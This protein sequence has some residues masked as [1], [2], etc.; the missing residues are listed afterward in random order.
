[1]TK[2]KAHHHKSGENRAKVNKEAHPKLDEREFPRLNQFLQTIIDNANVWL[3]VL[4]EK[5]NVVIWNNAA[6][7]ISGYSREEVVG[8]R[9]IWDWLYPDEEYRKWIM[10]SVADVLQRGRVDEDVETRIRRKDG[11]IRIISWNERNLVDE[12]GK[13]IGS[14]AIG[15]DVTERKRMQE[16]LEHYSKHLEQLVAERTGK[17]AE[18][19]KRFRELAHLLPQIVFEIDEKANLTFLNHIAFASTGYSED[20]LRKGLNAFQ[21]FV[22]ED[23]NRVMD[24]MRRIMNGEKLGGNEYTALRKD[25]STFPIIIHSSPIILEGKAAG[26]RGIAIDMTERKQMEER[27]LKSQR[28]AAIGELAAMVGHD[29]R[30][31][32]TGIAGAAYLL[33]SRLGSQIDDKTRG[34]L[35]VIEKNVEY[36]DKIISDLLEYSGELRLQPT[37]TSVKSITQDALLSVRIPGNVLVADLTE[38]EPEITADDQ[39]MRRVFVNIIRNAVEA[40]PEGGTLTIS[41]KRTNDDVDV[42]FADTGVGMTTEAMKKLWTPL[43]TTKA[44]GMGLGLVICKRIV[45][46]HGGSISAESALGRGSTFTVKLPIKPDLKEVK[47]T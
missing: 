28:L 27:L 21:M 14:I 41:S 13:V 10:D 45:E 19:E 33:R 3:D 18:S 6:E 36:S 7:V 39:K 44:K 37:V 38:N 2:T 15:R 31:P 32:L 29:L 22:P 26:L 43:F 23:R 46:A 9:E 40:M 16:E 25:G 42:V 8:H 4:D 20:D 11:Q 12:H 24:N 5:A 30:N 35:E 17:L 47:E 34:L 1:M